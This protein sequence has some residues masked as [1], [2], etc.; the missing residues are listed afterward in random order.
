MFDSKTDLLNRAC[1]SRQL[2]YNGFS[3]NPTIPWMSD[4]FSVR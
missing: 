4:V 1:V 3:T 2:L